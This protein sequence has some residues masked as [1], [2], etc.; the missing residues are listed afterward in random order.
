MPG[1]DQQAARALMVCH[2]VR[3]LQ[4]VTI[5]NTGIE[6]ALGELLPTFRQ[7][8]VHSFLE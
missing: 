1:A 4:I 7:N 2:R 5:L 6:T 8:V 3:E